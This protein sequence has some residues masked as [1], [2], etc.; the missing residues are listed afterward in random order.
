MDLLLL[1]GNGKAGGEWLP[2]VE[3]AL[4]G[5]F[6]LTRMLGYRHWSTGESEIDLDHEVSQAAE[7]AMDLGRYGVFAKSAGTMV[8][9]LATASGKLTP[10]WCLFAGLP[11]VMINNHGLPAKSWLEATHFPITIVQNDSDPYGSYEEVNDFLQTLDRP[12][13]EVLE[14]PGNTHDYTDFNLLKSLADQ[15]VSD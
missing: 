1:P 13:I 6:D 8:T 3:Q 4:A 2:R 12:N 11:L 14:A 15:L 9:A 7:K 10:E 5:S